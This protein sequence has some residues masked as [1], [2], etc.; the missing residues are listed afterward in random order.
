MAEPVANTWR[1]Y[2]FQTG[3]QT[4]ILKIQL[5]LNKN[6]QLSN[7]LQ[8]WQSAKIIMQIISIKSS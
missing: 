4:Q 5:C 7:T 2:A 6:C 1:I 8:G 3:N